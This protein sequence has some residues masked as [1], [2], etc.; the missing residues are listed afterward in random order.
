VLAAAAVLLGDGVEVAAVLS[1]DSWVLGAGV[2]GSGIGIGAG[3]GEAEI[4]GLEVVALATL[5]AGVF[6]GLLASVAGGAVRSRACGLLVSTGVSTTGATA[7]SPFALATTGGG[8]FV[9][10]TL[11]VR[12]AGCAAVS[13]VFM[14]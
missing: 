6:V 10:V 11:E 4:D 8:V 13:E 1:T 7:L 14:V 9:S 5:F 3:V 2:T 12:G